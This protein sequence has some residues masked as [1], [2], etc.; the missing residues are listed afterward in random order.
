MS[1]FSEF[2]HMLD[3]T[4]V[5]FVTGILSTAIILLITELW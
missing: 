4:D 2:S 3:G 1:N 5:G